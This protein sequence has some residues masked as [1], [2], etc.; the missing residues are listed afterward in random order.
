MPLAIAME[1]FLLCFLLG[2]MLYHQ[3]APARRI[4]DILGSRPALTA[5]ERELK[6]PFYQ[7]AVKPLLDKWSQKLIKI[8][9]AEKEAELG[10]RINHAHLQHKIAPRELMILK[11]LASAGGAIGGGLVAA[12]YFQQLGG[13]LAFCLAGLLAGWYGPDFYLHLRARERQRAIEKSLPD[14]LD[15][16][17]V[18]VEAGLGFDSALLKVV[19]K[20]KGPLTEELGLT[21]QEIRMGKPRAEALRDLAARTGVDELASFTGAV[22][23]AD[24]LGLSIGNVL[25]LQAKQLR[26]K[27]RQRAEELAMKAP[28]KMLIPLVFFIFPSIFVILLGPAVIQLTRYFLK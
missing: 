3:V 7:R 1:V 27:R 19:E 8:L 11:Y 22:I 2:F 9:P 21:L 26:L 16:L 10:R 28:V 24:Q 18:S 5:R 13:L 4:S 25:R 6:I 15:L 14:V 20:S 12:G 23:L 17:T